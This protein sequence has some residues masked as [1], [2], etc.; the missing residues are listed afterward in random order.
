ML[1]TYDAFTGAGEVPQPGPVFIHAEPCVRHGEQ[2]GYPEE[3]LTI[4][5]V[6]D[7]YSKDQRLVESVRVSQGHREA[8]AKLLEN[9]AVDYIQVRDK[10]AGC[11]DFRVER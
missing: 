10:N 6:L 7:A 3:L 9:Q 8:V 5:G 11:F 4:P 1:F 2:A